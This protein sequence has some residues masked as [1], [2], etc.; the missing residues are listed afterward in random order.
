MIAKFSKQIKTR[1][2]KFTKGRLLGLCVWD[3][4][5]AEIEGVAFL[6]NQQGS[7]SSA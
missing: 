5:W 4:A 2:A 7:T 3:E 1:Q 6:F